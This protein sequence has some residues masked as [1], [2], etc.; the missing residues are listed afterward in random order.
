MA[1]KAIYVKAH[2]RKA[3]TKKKAS[4]SM[5]KSDTFFFGLGLFLFGLLVV[6]AVF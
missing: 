1:S 4:A 5:S 2:Y 3:S 6:S